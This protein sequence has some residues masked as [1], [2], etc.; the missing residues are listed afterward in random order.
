MMRYIKVTTH[1]DHG[2]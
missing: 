2:C 1:R